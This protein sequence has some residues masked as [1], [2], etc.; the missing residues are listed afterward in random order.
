MRKRRTGRSIIGPG[1]LRR[2]SQRETAGVDEEGFSPVETVAMIGLAH[3]LRQR[4]DELGDA[5]VEVCGGHVGDAD[6]LCVR[7]SV[8]KGVR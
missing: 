1:R 7:Q 6:D 3:R 2:R 4:F 5:G 8:R